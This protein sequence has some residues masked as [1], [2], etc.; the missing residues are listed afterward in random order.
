MY[1]LYVNLTKIIKVYH[2]INF[3]VCKHDPHSTYIYLHLILCRHDSYFAISAE[4]S[5]T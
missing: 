4:P 5:S 1:K 2:I 3:F